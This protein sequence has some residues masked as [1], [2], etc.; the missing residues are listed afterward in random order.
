MLTLLA[1]DCCW[2][3]GECD[4]GGAAIG[5]WIEGGVIELD[6]EWLTAWCGGRRSAGC[7]C[8]GVRDCCDA[9]A[10]TVGEY[11]LGSSDP[12]VVISYS[13]HRASS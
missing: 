3:L 2:L 1:C 7:R 11:D 5:Y 8:G 4:R 6:V 10:G 12:A 9:C 13:L